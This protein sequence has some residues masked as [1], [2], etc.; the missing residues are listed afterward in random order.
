MKSDKE[1]IN[2]EQLLDDFRIKD[3]ESLRIYM[4]ELWKDLSQRS[5]DKNKGVNRVTFAKYYNLPGIILDRLFNVF[6]QDN[7]DFL[8]CAEFVE[9]MVTLNSE[10]FDKLIKFI[11]K[12]YDFDKNDAISQEDIRVVL[13]YIPLNI[14]NKCKEKLK[15]EV[16]DYKDRIESQ[17]E[18]NSLLTKC[19][20]SKKRLSF[21]EFCKI[22]E[23]E[24]SEIYLYIL[25]FL[26]ESKPF[27]ASSLTIYEGITKSS[28]KSPDN[29]PKTPIKY[30]ASPNLDSKLSPGNSIKKSPT[31]TKSKINVE[32]TKYLGNNSVLSS[33]TGK[34][35]ISKLGPDNIRNKLDNIIKNSSNNNPTVN[36]GNKNPIRK[37][38]ENLKNIEQL[39]EKK[40]TVEANKDLIENDEDLK[41]IDK[42]IVYTNNQPKKT[43]DENSSDSD[44]EDSKEEINYE[45]Y[46]YKITQTKKLKVLFFKLIN[47]DLYCKLNYLLFYRL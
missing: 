11:F 36:E 2:V 46:L 8:D 15:Y 16:A 10:N 14:R 43:Y 28:N 44:I 1:L 12:F 5:E 21:E 29:K 38:R 3:K 34:S 25:V 32:A 47:K 19:F 23:E 35:P 30:I 7:N 24:Y 4:K 26:L 13:S 27:S 31:I 37:Q 45:G 18:L 41:D 40:K 33:L 17:D 6:D 42:V 20:K 39:D 22:V 9:G